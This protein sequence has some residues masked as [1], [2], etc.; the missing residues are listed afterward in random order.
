MRVHSTIV[1]LLPLTVASSR[2]AISELRRVAF[3]A[4]VLDELH[5]L[6]RNGHLP[7]VEE[8]LSPA[9]CP[10]IGNF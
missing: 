4:P 5:G 1:I 8:P 10:A 7:T 2:G 6:K 9:P 3:L